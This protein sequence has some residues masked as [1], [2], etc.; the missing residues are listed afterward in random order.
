MSGTKTDKINKAKKK[1]G[2]IFDFNGNPRSLKNPIGK[3]INAGYECPLDAFLKNLKIQCDDLKDDHIK[4]AIEKVL[5][6]NIPLDLPSEFNNIQKKKNSKSR[7]TGYHVFLSLTKNATIEEKRAQWK[8]LSNEEKSKY[9][10][11][12]NDDNNK[13]EHNNTK[14]N[15][16]ED[17][18]DKDDNKDNNIEEDDDKEDDDKDNNNEEDD[19]EDE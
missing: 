10:K 16:E 1:D 5:S 13:K 8:S 6:E 9:N 4:K 2:Y 18:D 17:D 12:A 3:S 19:D 11:L 15:I 7:K 14:D